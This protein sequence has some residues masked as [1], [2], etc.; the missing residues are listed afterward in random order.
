MSQAG[1]CSW[2]V[3]VSVPKA[4]CAIV[5]VTAKGSGVGERVTFLAHDPVS[6]GQRVLVTVVRGGRGQVDVQ[7]CLRQRNKMILKGRGLPRWR[8]LSFPQAPEAA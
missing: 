6:T 7:H 2:C 4:A 1:E 3:C 8:G 5:G